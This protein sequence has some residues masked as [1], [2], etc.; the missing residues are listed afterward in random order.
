MGLANAALH[1][2]L[3]Q[4]GEGYVSK[5]CAFGLKFGIAVGLGLLGIG[6]AVAQQSQI[7]FADKLEEIVV[8]AQKREEH[9]QDV[10]V[11]ISVI[12]TDALMQTYQ[13]R[14]QDYFSTVPGLNMQI[15]GESGTPYL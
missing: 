13:L 1:R 6:S 9:L 4:W 12:H 7:E 10:P 3:E 11:P 2:N 14:L 5:R 8:T 15:A